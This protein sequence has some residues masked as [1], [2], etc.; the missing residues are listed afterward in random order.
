M[1]CGRDRPSAHCVTAIIKAKSNKNV[2]SQGQPPTFNSPYTSPFGTLFNH[3]TQYAAQY[4]AQYPAQYTG[5]AL[6]GPPGGGYGQPYGQPPLT[7]GGWAAP[8]LGGPGQPTGGAGRGAGRNDPAWMTTNK[9]HALMPPQA[10]GPPATEAQC[11]V[12]QAPRFDPATN[13]LLNF[14][15]DRFV[16]SQGPKIGTAPINRTSRPCRF[17]DERGHFVFA[18]PTLNRW[19]HAELGKPP[20]GGHTRATE[21]PRWNLGKAGGV[22]E[23]NTAVQ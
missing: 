9:Q 8:Q 22:S 17:C 14:N 5:H 15:N 6:P 23:V 19:L 2:P 1:W 21:L 7:G 18:C 16:I 10:G 13:A 11:M 3:D 20:I 12:G 4:A